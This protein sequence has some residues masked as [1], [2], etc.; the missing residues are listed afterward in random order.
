EEVEEIEETEESVQSDLENGETIVV[1][2]DQSTQESSSEE[3]Q[4]Q[5]DSL[6]SNLDEG[7]TVVVSLD[8]RETQKANES[9]GIVEFFYTLDQKEWKSLGVVSDINNDVEFKLPGEITNN[10]SNLSNLEIKIK[11]GKNFNTQNSTL[12]I[13]ALWLE[14]QKPQVLNKPT[15]PPVISKGRV[16]DKNI[17]VATTSQH[18][19]Q[20]KEFNLELSQVNSLKNTLILQIQNTTESLVEIGGL[21]AGVDVR[22][23][24]KK[25]TYQ[26][27]TQEKEIGLVI[28]KQQLGKGS[29]SVPIIYTQDG[30]ST[31][32]QMNINN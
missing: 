26:P 24:N 9:E 4:T 29:F 21:P 25:Y 1:N 3:P 19:C 22:F 11:T 27:K 2:F 32:C 30:I 13:D 15:K 18:S 28:T 6:Q 12:F 17:K 20:L 31:I 10:L 5:D 8:G 7:E 16:Y 23:A 14:A